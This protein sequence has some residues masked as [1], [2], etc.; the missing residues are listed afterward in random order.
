M[1]RERG[2][3]RAE[4]AEAI[5]G[6]RRRPRRSSSA[7]VKLEDVARQAGVSTA[8]VSRALN[9]PHLVSPE[10]RDRIAQAAL[11]LNWV[12]NGVAK[13]LASLRTRTVG[14]MIPTLSHQNFAILIE[15]LQHDLAA[16]HY[17]LILCCTDVSEE[18]RLKQARKLIE[19]GVE[20]LVLVGEAQP[21]GLF[22][23]LKSQNVPYV[24]TYTSGRDTMH[25]CIGFDN[26]A[27]AVQLTE[28][29]L[30]LGHLDFG[31]VAHESQGND[32]IQER[33]AGV[34]DT[35]ARSGIAIRPQHFARVDSRHIASGRDGM[36]RILADGRLRPTALVCTND[37][38]ATGAMIE[39]KQLNLAIP[40][41]LSI[42]GFDDTDMSAHLDPP[43]TTIRVPSRRM[44]EEI[45]RYIIG[46]LENGSTDC[47][48]P[49]DAELIIRSSTAPPPR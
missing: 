43:L 27:A 36:R 34:Q 22:Q 39:A 17:M 48:P 1:E 10:L 24:I 20:C 11:A 19:Q 35:L 4:R 9:T 42:V 13:A 15:A 5:V 8:S 14:V 45:A 21:D 37:Y 26:Y 25:T 33:I 23:L 18:L 2:V 41:D 46:Y 7:T 38:I 6:A 28:H 16:A 31:M 3:I 49:L 32:R 40:R 12:P 47:P 44:G 29:M 30:A